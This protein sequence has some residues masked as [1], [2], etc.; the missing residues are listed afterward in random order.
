MKLKRNNLINKIEQYAFKFSRVYWNI[1]VTLAFAALVI[2]LFITIWAIIP[3]SEGSARKELI[4]SRPSN[5]PI[6]S[7]SFEE[8]QKKITPEPEPKTEPEPKP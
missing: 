6:A 8:I 3:T 5:P 1:I 2:S 7:V 4:P